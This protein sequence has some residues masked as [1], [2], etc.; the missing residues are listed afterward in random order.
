MAK[1]IA[2]ANQKGGVGKPTTAINLGASLAVAETRVLIVDADPQGNS[3]SGLGLRGKFRRSL[4]HSLVLDEPIENTILTTELHSLQLVPSDR[5]LVAAE[6]ELVDVPQREFVLKKCL[7]PVLERYEYILIDCPPSLGL[8]TLNALSA[9]NSVLVPIQCEYFALEGVS[10]LWDTLVKIRRNLNPSL[11]VEGFLLTMYDE[12]TNLSNQVV[13]DL[14]DFL[15]SQVFTTV[16]PRNIKL[17]EAPSYGK[18]IILYDIKSKGAESYLN[19]AREVIEN[20]KKGAG[21]GA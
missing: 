12:R 4:Y 7:E 13:S 20:V 10:E 3:T 16:I 9:A 2:I 17:A 8:L 5:V 19:L 1:V 11:A 21:Q 18:P 15:G 6:I 14:R